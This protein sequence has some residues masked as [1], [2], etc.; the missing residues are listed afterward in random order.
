LQGLGTQAQYWRFDEASDGR[1]VIDNRNDI[2]SVERFEEI[3]IPMICC[4][5]G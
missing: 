4:P 2:C 5:I 1:P 3:Q